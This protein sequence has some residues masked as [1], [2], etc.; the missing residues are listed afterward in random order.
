MQRI[1]VPIVLTLLVM[2]PARPVGLLVTGGER[3]AQAAPRAGLNEIAQ[4]AGCTLT[5]FADG[6]A[7]SNPPVTGRFVERTWA[8]DGSYAGRRAPTPLATIHDAARPGR[9]AAVRGPDRHAPKGRRHRIPQPDDVRVAAP[10]VA[11]EHHIPSTP[12]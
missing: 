11:H 10:V 12:N 4:K 1:P 6:S 5:N 8:S 2:L 3:P 9:S 7:T